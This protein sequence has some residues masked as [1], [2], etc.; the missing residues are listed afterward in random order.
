MITDLIYLYN[1]IFILTM[2]S[3]N[4]SINLNHYENSLDQFPFNSMNILLYLRTVLVQCTDRE[5]KTSTL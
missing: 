3:N 2:N 4:S 1:Y 5:L